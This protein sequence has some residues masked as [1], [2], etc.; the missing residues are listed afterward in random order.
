[1]IRST[2]ETCERF[3][4]A[5]EY[6]EIAV[7]MEYG[8]MRHGTNEVM[9]FNFN[10]LKLFYQEVSTVHYILLLE[11]SRKMIP[12]SNVKDNAELDVGNDIVLEKRKV[13][14]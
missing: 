3:I 2:I 6:E 12:I 1:M 9:N 11:S 7:C 10:L 4:Y 14:L 5:K 8:H 13:L